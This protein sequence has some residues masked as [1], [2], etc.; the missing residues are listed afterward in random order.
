MRRPQTGPS[1]GPNEVLTARVVFLSGDPCPRVGPAAVVIAAAP[2]DVPEVADPES[3]D[4]APPPARHR[5]MTYR[6]GG[7]GF[8]RRTT[9]EADQPNSATAVSTTTQRDREGCIGQLLGTRQG[10][11]G[12][13]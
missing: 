4:A 10:S 3:P 5:L 6:R 12:R 8:I 1:K 2:F 11:S 9:A 13:R 7:I